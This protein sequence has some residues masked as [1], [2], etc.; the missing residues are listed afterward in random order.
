MEHEKAWENSRDSRVDSWRKFV[1]KGGKSVSGVKKR[2]K[3]KAE[4][5]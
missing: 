3:E 5:L 1:K 2:L 4:L